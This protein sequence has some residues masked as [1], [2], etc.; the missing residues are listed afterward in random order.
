M[1]RP[2]GTGTD[3]PAQLAAAPFRVQAA[4]ASRQGPFESVFGSLLSFFLG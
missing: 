3:R 2:F 1:G 4:A